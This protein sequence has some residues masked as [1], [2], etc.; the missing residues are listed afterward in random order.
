[1]FCREN[2]ERSHLFRSC[3][4]FVCSRRPPQQQRTRRDAGENQPPRRSQKVYL[5]HAIC[6]VTEIRRKAPFP[7]WIFKF[8][9]PVHGTGP[10]QPKTCNV[11]KLL[12]HARHCRPIN[13]GFMLLFFRGGKGRFFWVQHLFVDLPS[14]IN[15]FLDLLQTRYLQTSGLYAWQ[16]AEKLFR[17]FRKYLAK[18]A[19][20]ICRI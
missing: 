2:R 3:I 10:L 5:C 15:V 8:E 11:K 19:Q 1:M 13:H 7:N 18:F 6:S 4:F 20:Q 16:I 12:S 14:P 17:T 9:P